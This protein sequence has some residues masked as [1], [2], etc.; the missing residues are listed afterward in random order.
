MMTLFV[1]GVLPLILPLMLLVSWVK[2]V[3]SHCHVIFL[4]QIE[5]ICHHAFLIT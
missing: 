5:Q 1:E 2:H 4:P 3:R